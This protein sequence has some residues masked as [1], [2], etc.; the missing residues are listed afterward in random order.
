[1][2][3][4]KPFAQS[5]RSCALAFS[6]TWVSQPPSNGRRK[7]FKNVQAFCVLLPCP[8]TT[9]DLSRDQATAIFRIFQEILTNVA[10]HAQA[11]KVWVHLGEEHG[12]NCAG[13]R[14]QRRRDFARAVGGAPL[15]GV[16]WECVS[17]RWAFGGAVEIVGAS[18]SRHHRDSSRCRY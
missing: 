17:G 15:P 4:C 8:E 14:G 13:S 18:R 5:P 12:R 10:R 16:A 9:H 7:I 11:T 3:Q 1:M 6:M 2:K